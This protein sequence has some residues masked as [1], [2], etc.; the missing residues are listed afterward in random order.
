MRHAQ[1]RE[2]RDNVQPQNKRCYNLH[3][4][5]NIT[6]YIAGVGPL[7]NINE[8]GPHYTTNNVQSSVV[9]NNP[10]QHCA[11]RTPATYYDS[12]RPIGHNS[13]QLINVIEASPHDNKES[14]NLQVRASIQLHVRTLPNP[15]QTPLIHPRVHNITY[16]T[17]FDL[18]H[19]ILG[20]NQC[21]HAIL[22]GEV[23]SLTAA[24]FH[25]LDVPILVI[26]GQIEVSLRRCPL[27]GHPMENAPLNAVIAAQKA[28][29]PFVGHSEDLEM[30]KRCPKPFSIPSISA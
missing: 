1:N 3:Q 24:S 4:S 9:Y 26:Y 22:S 30:V 20:G 5:P 17:I 14:R 19:H 7:N 16:Y 10:S 25:S 21:S 28:E 15:L 6:R 18:Q 12:Q 23:P 11:A 29:A 27:I 8:R 2:T 13:Q